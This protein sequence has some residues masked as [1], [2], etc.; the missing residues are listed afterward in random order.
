MLGEEPSRATKLWFRLPYPVSKI[1]FVKLILWIFQWFPVENNANSIVMSWKKCAKWWASL[2]I[3]HV[4]P[5]AWSG[6]HAEC[7]DSSWY[8]PAL[9]FIPANKTSMHFNSEDHHLKQLV[10]IIF[11]EWFHP[12]WFVWFHVV[13][14]DTLEFERIYCRARCI[15]ND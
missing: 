2:L 13:Y 10:Q 11:Y 6:L 7:P 9:K 4:F 14:G 5:C 3:L 12:R 1:W 8:D 15:S